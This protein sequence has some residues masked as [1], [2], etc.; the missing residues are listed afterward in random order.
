MNT[1]TLNISRLALSAYLI[2]CSTFAIAQADKN[3]GTFGGEG[4]FGIRFQHY[5]F[6]NLNASFKSNGLPEIN[7]NI[8]SFS[9]GGL[10]YIDRLIIGGNGASFKLSAK[11]NGTYKSNVSGGVGFFNIGYL[12]YNKPKFMIYPLL[13]IGGSS[14]KIEIYENSK[15]DFAQLITNP[16]KGT[17]IENEQFLLDLGVQ[18]NLFLT[19][20]KMF[21]IGIKVGYQFT[22]LES[23]WFDANG[24]LTN[25]P[26]TNA[27]GI[28]TQLQFCFGGFSK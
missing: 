18:S 22:P 15:T 28:Y 9:G 23:D 21:G 2:L 3:Y 19:K 13:G 5:D 6:K 14:M 27:D 24:T 25:S 12:L 8:V 1:R 16:K 4:N 26:A 7:E 10:A 20:H 17:V 11:D